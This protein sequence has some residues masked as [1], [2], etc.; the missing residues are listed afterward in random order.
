MRTS[1]TTRHRNPLAPALVAACFLLP[2]PAPTAE[3]GE[4]DADHL[5]RI[6]AGETI[7]ERGVEPEY[8]DDFPIEDYRFVPSGSS[9]FWIL[10]PGYQLYL[11]GDD[12]GEFVE[13]FITVLKEKRTI[14]LEI[15]GRQ[16]RIRTRV[17]EEREYIDGELVEVSENY[18][19]RCKWTDDTYYF[20]EAVCNYEDGECVNN[21][22]SWLAGVDGATPG[23]IMPGTFLLG[24]RYFQEVAPGIALDRAENVRMGET[25][26]TDAGEFEGCAVVLETTPL[27][28]GAE[29]EKTYAPGVGLNM[30]GPIS[31]V[32]YGFENFNEH[33][34]DGGDE[35]GGE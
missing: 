11:A 2:A 32:A 23:I 30:D 33:D 13:V 34:D 16:Q 26:L 10:E 15:D 35:E 17:I 20:G 14:F 22:G 8:T 31:L 18:F 27:E 4:I 3:G 28:P 24:S 29:D 5:R 9:R 12:D 6:L 25:V 7:V 19:A 21:N 1:V